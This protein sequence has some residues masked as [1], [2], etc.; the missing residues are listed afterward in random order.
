[1]RPTHDRDEGA[2][3][4]EG[5]RG[6]AGSEGEPQCIGAEVAQRQH[7]QF[8]DRDAEA[9]QQQDGAEADGEGPLGAHQLLARR[10]DAAIAMQGVDA[11]AARPLFEQDQQADDEHDHHRQ[12]RGAAEIGA[13]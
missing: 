11:V 4:G 13:G 1:M 6:E 3:R 10:G 12:L 7:Q 5:Y 8:A 9:E 2:E